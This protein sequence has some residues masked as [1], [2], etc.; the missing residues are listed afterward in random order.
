MFD[1]IKS[2]GSSVAD[3]MTQRA[4]TLFT[5]MKDKKTDEEKK[6]RGL[7]F[8]IFDKDE[9]K[10][11]E[12]EQKAYDKAKTTIDKEKE[13]KE[14]EEKD[15]TEKKIEKDEKRGEEA[16]ELEILFDKNIKA[17]I[18]SDF[19]YRKAPT[20]GASSNHSGID[21]QV[22]EG[23][24]VKSIADGT[25]VAAREGMRGYG[26]G[27]FVDHGIINGKHVIS[28]YGHL[29]KYDVKIGDKIKKGQIIAKSGNTGVSTGPHLHITIRED[30]EPVNPRKYFK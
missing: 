1:K 30:K 7:G 15:I 21:I 18:T 22:P 9:E 23:T 29:S 27:V 20:K 10:P 3:K 28:E 12:I 13:E 5:S 19:G 17:K 24:P 26:T 16:N 14:I 8:S 11:K 2:L 6:K 25:I 4:N